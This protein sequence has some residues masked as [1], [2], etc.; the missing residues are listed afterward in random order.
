MG[1]HS[2]PGAPSRSALI[3]CA[4]R[5]RYKRCMDY[6]TKQIEERRLKR[7]AL[8]REIGEA[9]AAIQRVQEE[10][11][12]LDAELRTYLDIA[13]HRPE[14][15]IVGAHGSKVT[16]GKEIEAPNLVQVTASLPVWL[17][18][19]SGDWRR[20]Y[21]SLIQVGM[22]FTTG[23]VMDLT[24]GESDPPSRKSIRGT[25]GK[26]VAKGFLERIEDGHFR[27]AGV[28]PNGSELRGQLAL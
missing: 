20:Y 5:E 23:D 13:E 7:R 2:A 15:A 24:R 21:E 11:K 25:L 14:I 16:N 17:A 12:I 26:H 22:E 28:N 1:A 8:E 6:L 27:F 18:N 9:E 19:V 10:L 3:D 4:A